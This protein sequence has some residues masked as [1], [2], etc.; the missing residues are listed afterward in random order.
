MELWPRRG[1][2]QSFSSV[3]TWQ[4]GPKM[5]GFMTSG[6]RGALHLKNDKALIAL[7]NESKGK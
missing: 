7:Y 1:G 4:L 2:R 3:G 6:C 5:A